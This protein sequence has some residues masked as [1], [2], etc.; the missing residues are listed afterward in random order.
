MCA[1]PHEHV[2]PTCQDPGGARRRQ[3]GARRSQDEQG[4]VRRRRR[5]DE[6]PPAKS[7][8]RAKLLYAIMA[9][10]ICVLRQLG[11]PTK[12]SYNPCVLLAFFQVM[13]W[14]S[15]ALSRNGGV[16][17]TSPPNLAQAHTFDEAVTA[18]IIIMAYKLAISWCTSPRAFCPSWC[19]SSSGLIAP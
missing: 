6:K 18:H 4:G 19:R 17:G 12:T 3:G 11:C 13:P 10:L 16:S 8:G 9:L 5:Q 15:W 7:G 14:T 1:W 2:A